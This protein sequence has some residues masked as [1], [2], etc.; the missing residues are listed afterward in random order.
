MITIQP[1]YE[2]FEGIGHFSKTLSG[3]D[4]IKIAMAYSCPPLPETLLEFVIDNAWQL[5]MVQ[6]EHARQIRQ[7]MEGKT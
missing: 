5:Q 7:L 4:A 3:I 2:A 6:L 1:H